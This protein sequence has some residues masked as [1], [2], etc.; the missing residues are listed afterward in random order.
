MRTHFDH[1]LGKFL[2]TLIGIAYQLETAYPTA[3]TE[4]DMAAIV[5][6]LP[7]SGFVL[8]AAV[9]VLKLGEAFLSWFLVLAIVVEPLDSRPCTI[10]MGLTSLGVELSSKGIFFS[11]YSTVGLQVV[12][13]DFLAVH[14]QPQAFVTD[15]LGSANSLIDG[16]ILLLAPT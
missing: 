1:V 3:I 5:V 4:C 10:S 15:K 8:D 11:E 12:F 14:P 13:G 9:V 2:D 6:K 7:P 16:G